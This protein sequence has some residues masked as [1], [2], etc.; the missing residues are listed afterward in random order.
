M[1]GFRRFGSS[2]QRA[3]IVIGA[4]FILIGFIF[5]GRRRGMGRPT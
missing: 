5:V 2:D 4:A 1:A 3:F